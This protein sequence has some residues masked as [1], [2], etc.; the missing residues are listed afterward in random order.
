[1][2]RRGRLDRDYVA[3]MTSVGRAAGLILL[4]PT[5]VAAEATAQSSAPGD[6]RLQTALKVS[7]QIETLL[8]QTDRNCGIFLLEFNRPVESTQEFWQGAATRR[9]MI[10]AVRCVLDARRKGRS[11]SALWQRAGIDATRFGGVASSPVSDPLLVDFDSMRA[12][13]VALSP[14]L[15][16]RVARDGR[17]DCRN[18]ARPLSRRDLDR[19]LSRLRRDVART[20]G[21][22]HAATVDR[23]S[24][25]LRE[26]AAGGEVVAP[27]RVSAAIADVQ[28]AVQA[29]AGHSAWP[30]CPRHHDHA[31]EERDHHWYCRRDRVFIAEIG[32]LARAGVP[33]ALK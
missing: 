13:G 9:Q 24:G 31:L 15:R 21:E 30:V 6:P 27:A 3:G 25:R 23:A 20:A 2:R 18:T 17:I 26:S 28:R 7:A 29:E 12:D 11:A 1:M 10:D 14:C 16:P 8:G 5:V 33:T 4:L 19:T 32:G 22:A